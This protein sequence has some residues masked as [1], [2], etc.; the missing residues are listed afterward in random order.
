MAWDEWA[1]KF[2]FRE[3]EDA[4][5]DCEAQET[6]VEPP[7]ASPAQILGHGSCDDRSNL[8]YKN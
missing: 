1:V 2:R 3:E 7:E 6:R 8:E 4:A 5:Y